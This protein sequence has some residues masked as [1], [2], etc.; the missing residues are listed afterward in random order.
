M[1]RLPAAVRDWWRR[2][3]NLVVPDDK[4]PKPMEVY[5]ALLREGE[6]N[7]MVVLNRT[8][9]PNRF[10]CHIIPSDAHWQTTLGVLLEPKRFAERLTADM[11]A[12]RRDFLAPVKVEFR[13]RSPGALREGEERIRVEVAFDRT[14]QST[15]HDAD[16]ERVQHP[17]LP[18]QGDTETVLPIAHLLATT[19][20]LKERTFTLTHSPFRIGRDPKE[21]DLIL[22]KSDLSASRQHATLMRGM[23]GT[24]RL[25]DHSRNG[26]YIKRKSDGGKRAVWVKLTKGTTAILSP[27][28]EFRVGNTV[29]ECLGAD[30]T[31]STYLV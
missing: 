16:T 8:V 17:P 27:G 9:A 12:A 23:D 21:N 13:Y 1:S 28:A 10:V 25:Q 24:W 11:Q 6:R 4:H 7:V 30:N 29:F 3:Q 20:E 2:L 14:P 18:P 5:N 26:T 22:P 19:G 31:Q 15:L